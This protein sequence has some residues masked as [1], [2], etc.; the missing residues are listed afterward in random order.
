ML[1]TRT[2]E[3][4]QDSRIISREV[5]KNIVVSCVSTSIET[6]DKENTLPWSITDELLHIRIVA[7]RE[8]SLET[9]SKCLDLA[10]ILGKP[11]EFVRVQ[12]WSRKSK[13]RRE[14]IAGRGI[15]EVVGED[16]RHL[17]EIVLFQRSRVY[18]DLSFTFASRP[19]YWLWSPPFLLYRAH[20]SVVADD[21]ETMTTIIL[22]LFEEWASAV[23]AHFGYLLLDPDESPRV[24]PFLSSRPLGGPTPLTDLISEIGWATYFG[25]DL[26]M[27]VVRERLETAPAWKIT[28]TSNGGIIILLSPSPLDV[29][30][31]RLARRRI[32]EH[33]GLVP[34]DGR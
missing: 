6:V 9:I 20:K 3:C 33:L 7:S 24:G 25:P 11:G 23:S 13:T 22:K 27:A 14:L 31:N 29:E 34:L 28:A 1:G 8:F 10:R 12:L 21:P 18:S 30:G 15:G 16:L 5:C 2:F 32:T 19:E 4:I 17:F 26:A